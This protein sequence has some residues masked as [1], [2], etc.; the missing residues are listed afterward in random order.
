MKK[1]KN[2]YMSSIYQDAGKTTM[3]LGLYKAFREKKLKTTF[4]KPVGQQAIFIDDREI[5]KD[6]YLIGEVFHCHKKIKDMSPVTIP[7]GFTEKYIYDP[8]KEVMVNKILKSFKSLTKGKDSIIIEGTGHAAVGSVVDL[9]NADVASLLG[10]KVIIVSEGGIGRSIDEIML[11]KALFDLK[12]VEVIGVIINKVLPE[13]YSKIKRVLKQGLKNKGIKLLGVIPR[14]PILSDPS[15]EHL[16]NILDLELLCGKENLNRR[17]RNTIVAAMEPENMVE[18][19]KDG[20]L[21]L[22]S[23]D[24]VDNIMVAVSSH[25]IMQGKKSQVSGMIL[26]G[27]L[28][29]D[30]KITELLKKSGIPVLISEDDIY[31]IA[32]KMD[33]LTC[34]IQKTDKEKIAEAVS[35]VKEYVDIDAI[36][37]S[38]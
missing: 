12:G 29:P 31:T 21:I 18:Y 9:S 23:G 19:I 28:T 20:T 26:S 8:Q 13:K 37:S 3:S 5:D 14:D 33:G 1:L 22:T 16:M 15:M 34:K 6:S 27:G 25:F 10:S 32:G 24:R 4:C 30:V 11:N 38:L 17:V 35:L 2:I 7:R 36:L